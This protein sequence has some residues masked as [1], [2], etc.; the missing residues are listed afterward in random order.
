MRSDRFSLQ[1]LSWLRKLQYSLMGSRFQQ[2]SGVIDMQL[3]Y[4]FSLVLFFISITGCTKPVAFTSLASKSTKLVT[5][6]CTQDPNETWWEITGKKLVDC[7]TCFDNSTLKCEVALEEEFMCS[8]GITVPTG[9]VRD[10]AQQPPANECPLPPMKNCG[11]HLHES[12]WWMDAEVI[13][14]TCELCPDGSAHLCNVV[15][16]AEKKCFDGDISNTGNAREG[17][18]LGY[19]NECPPPPP[20]SCGDKPHGT[21]WW[22]EEGSRSS[23][24]EICPDGT[25]H[26]CNKALENEKQCLDGVISNT[27]DTRDGRFLGYTNECLPLP[28]KNCGEHAHSSLWWIEGSSETVKGCG[29]CYDGSERTCAYAVEDQYRCDDG[30]TATTGTQ[31]DGRYLREVRA[32]PQPPKACGDHDSGTKWWVENGTVQETCEL[33]WNG[34]PHYCQKAKE[35]EQL[36]T[37]GSTSTTGATRTGRML[38]WVNVCPPQNITK[39]ESLT[40]PTSGNKVDILVVLDTSG[41]MD[42]EL[43]KMSKRFKNFTSRL[44]GLDW[45]I[46]ITNALTGTTIYDGFSQ[47]GKL[48]KLEGPTE[49]IISD[50]QIIKKGDRYAENYFNLTT[51]RGDWEENCVYPPYCASYK[52]QPLKQIIKT[53]EVQK[54]NNT[55]F[56]R[57]GAS[58][59]PLIISDDDEKTDPGSKTPISPEQVMGYFEKNLKGQAA[60]MVGYS[61]IVQPGDEQCLKAQSNI[62]NNGGHYGYSLNDF[63]SKTGGFSASI[64][65]GD[66]GQILSRI[67]EGI[68]QKVDSFELQSVPL[69]GTLQVVFEPAA[70]ITWTLAGKTVTFS[71]SLPAG[72]KVKFTYQV[73]P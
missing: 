25:D 5:P 69:P 13:T 50:K 58:F 70:G 36:C 67:S 72:T 62:W 35:E 22:I 26:T 31:R 15:T 39:N 23:T 53:M 66:F 38:G 51:S 44:E 18:M 68:R 46:G 3:R 4:V 16:E 34:D 65:E 59:V 49:H 73:R 24:C 60:N 12:L 63:A 2:L 54:A 28:P 57:P 20:K 19:I 27:G 43:E 21:K 8:D 71:Q 41:S 9:E 17:R 55:G 61:I 40:A 1:F 10:G 56:F 42:R 11:E 14:K 48:F 37:D 45:Q 52:S 32:C 30:A 7:Q 33:C 64:C 47:N 6:P 29:S